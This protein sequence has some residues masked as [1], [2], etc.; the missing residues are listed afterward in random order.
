MCRPRLHGAS[1]CCGATSRR[2]LPGRALVRRQAMRAPC[3]WSATSAASEEGRPC[4]RAAGAHTILSAG[5]LWEAGARGRHAGYAR[6]GDARG[7]TGV[8]ERL[9][10]PN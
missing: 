10:A 1:S 7:T 2:R 6:R 4:A 3:V 9:A 8:P 5:M